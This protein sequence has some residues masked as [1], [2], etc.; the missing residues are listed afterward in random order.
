MVAKLSQKIAMSLYKSNAINLEDREVYAY[1]IQLLLLSI[2]DWSITFFIMILTKQILLS[3]LY[4]FVFM[5]LRH[6]CGGYHA[7]THLRCSLAFNL[8]YL[9]SLY[10]GVIL[11]ETHLFLAFAAGEMINL[12]I[13]FRYSPVMHKNKPVGEV[14]LR[15]HKITGRILNVLFTI[16]AIFFIYMEQISCG[17]MV[18][19]AQLSVSL[20]II[21]EITK[22]RKGGC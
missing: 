11:Q 13:L 6:Q 4:F 19:F 12:V 16:T 9:V 14:Q 20:A 10:L 7:K 22:Q 8:V 21:L 3:V 5:T 18:M 2:I 1:G 17:W 15:K